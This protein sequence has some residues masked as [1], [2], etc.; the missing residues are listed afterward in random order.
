MTMLGSGN[1]TVASNP[2]PTATTRLGVPRA[3]LV[4]VDIHT[5]TANTQTSPHHIT[6]LAMGCGLDD[7]EVPVD[8]PLEVIHRIGQS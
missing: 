6:V 3:K 8:M 4:R 2:T 5:F 7:G 1:V